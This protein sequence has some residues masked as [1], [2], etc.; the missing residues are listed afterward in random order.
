MQSLTDQLAL[1]IQSQ[2]PGHPPQVESKRH[3]TGMWCMQCKQPGHTSQYCQ[4]RQNHEPNEQWREPTTKSKI[5]RI[6]M[7]KVT[8]EVLHLGRTSI[9]KVRKSTIIHVV[10]GML[11][12]NVGRMVRITVVTTVE[13]VTPRRNVGNR[14]MV[15]ME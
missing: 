5:G 10:G 1:V 14:I 13:V 6:S 8:I 11:K 4:N 7:G 2:H 12:V 3:A 15:E 9:M